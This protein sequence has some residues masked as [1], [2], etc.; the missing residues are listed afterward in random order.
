[1]NHTWALL[2][3]VNQKASLCN[4]ICIVRNF[5]HLLI[6][7]GVSKCM[8]SVWAVFPYSIKQN[9]AISKQTAKKYA[10]DKRT[11]NFKGSWKV[12]FIT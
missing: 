9:I 6:H 1:M 8:V 12:A 10:K 2:S 5:L 4:V 7:A 3:V 11:R